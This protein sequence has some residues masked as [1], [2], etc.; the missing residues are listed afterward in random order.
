MV[1]Y[2]LYD[3]ELTFDAAYAKEHPVL[4]WSFLISILILR[5]IAVC[6]SLARHPNFLQGCQD[7]LLRGYRWIFDSALALWEK[8]LMMMMKSD[9]TQHEQFFDAL[10][11]K[12]EAEGGFIL[13]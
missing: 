9:T 13:L 12:K 5:L 4:V 2:S 7:A 3:G 11:E 1:H 10:E 6:V 8:V